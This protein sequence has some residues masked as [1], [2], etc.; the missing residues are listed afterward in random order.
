MIVRL[1]AIFILAGL[2]CSPVDRDSMV[3]TSSHDRVFFYSEGAFHEIKGQDEADQ[4]I[5]EAIRLFSQADDIYLK[6]ITKRDLD[7]Y[8][9]SK[10]IEILFA[11]PREIHVKAIKED[12]EISKILI[13]LDEAMRKKHAHIIYGDPE[14]EEFNLVLNSEG[15][16]KLLKILSDARLMK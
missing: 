5:E 2:G 9:G 15:C 6:S 12:K 7:K 8:R 4:I 3:K 16:G 10:C 14:Y 13:P 11:Q 1:V